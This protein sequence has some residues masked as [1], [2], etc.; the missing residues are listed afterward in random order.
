MEPPKGQTL[1]ADNLNVLQAYGE[2]LK[3]SIKSII[4][5]TREESADAVCLEVAL[6][7]AQQ[8]VHGLQALVESIKELFITKT[9]QVYST[10]SGPTNSNSG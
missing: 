2:V 3:D 6:D 4:E 8:Q 9:N 7:I 10:Q 1:K 5:F